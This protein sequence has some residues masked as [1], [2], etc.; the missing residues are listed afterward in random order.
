MNFLNKEI[1]RISLPSILANITIPLVGMVD[2]AVAGHLGGNSAALI[3]G[4]TIGSMLFDLLYW[5]FGFLRAG[6]GGLTAQAFGRK[7][8]RAAADTLARST[9][10]ALI[11]A[12]LLIAIQ[13]VVIHIAFLVVDCSPEVRDLAQT[14]FLTRIWAAPAT[15][16]LMAFKGWFIG[17]QDSMSSMT[18]DMVVNILNIVCS[19]MLAFGFAGWQGLGY[20]AIAIGTVIAQY[21]G[22]CCALLII[23]S[24]Y[25][26]GVFMG[27]G[28]KDIY[29]AL[30]SSDMKSFF[31]LNGNLFIR[32][33]SFILVYIGFTF[34][35]A[36]YGDVALASSAILMKLMMLFSYFTDGFAYAGEAL[37]GRFIGEKDRAMVRKS[38]RYTFLWGGAI[39]IIF[40]II[41]AVFPRALFSVMTSNHEVLSFCMRHSIWLVLVPLAGCP[42][43]MW[44]GIFVGA[45]ASKQLRNSTVLSAII[46]IA[47]WLCAGSIAGVIS[48]PG[49]ECSFTAISILMGAYWMHLVVRAGYLTATYRS[50][51][52]TI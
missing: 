24:K 20:K 12:L 5:N 50:A 27:Y 30:T 36:K 11:A 29:K 47:I 26:K 43:F 41:N 31:G 16:L 1:L 46:F 21:S 52:L 9:G 48:S 2:I 34:I 44:D 19:V 22:L 10:I 6:T 17:M 38:V 37:T 39:A 33:V 49:E 8:F 35:S 13:T 42:A 25:R 3:G 14:Y 18:C 28:F 32:S 23:A 51:V 4:I 15:L 7:D 45:I 40:M